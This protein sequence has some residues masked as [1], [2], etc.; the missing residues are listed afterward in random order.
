MRKVR[1]LEDTLGASIGFAALHVES[2]ARASHNG[3]ERYPMRSVYKLPIAVAAFRLVDEGRLRLDSIVTVTPADFAPLYSPLRDRAR[4]RAVSVTVDSLLMLM[5]ADSDNT[6]SDVLLRLA[7]GPDAVTRHLRAWGATE[8][9][10]D[11]SERELATA[12]DSDADPRDTATPDAMA[13]LLVAVHSGRGLS[14]A[15]HQRLLEMMRQTRTGPNRIRALLPPGT[16]VAHKTGTGTP[17]TNDAG[18][19]TLP[20]GAGHVAVVVFVRGSGGS[21]AERERAI[22]EIARAVYDVF[23]RR[24]TAPA[25]AT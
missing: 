7:G 23:T 5:I 16:T 24:G 1:E 3:T 9:R 8:V 20:D 14:R 13:D 15:S 6:A 22:A 17:M 12:R 11:R 18:L 4:G 25:G 10:V 2:G 21:P 19:I